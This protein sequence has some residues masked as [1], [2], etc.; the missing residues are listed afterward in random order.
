MNTSCMY[1][2]YSDQSVYYFYFTQDAE[3]I[4]IL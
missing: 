3:R 4:V 1:F 2:D